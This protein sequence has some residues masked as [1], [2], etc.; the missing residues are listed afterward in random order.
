MT[1]LLS[2]FVALAWGHLWSAD[3]IILARSTKSEALGHEIDYL[4]Y[5]PPS[6]VADGSVR[7]P[8]L[9]LLHGRGDNFRAWTTVKPDVDRLIYEGRVPPFI[10]V[11]PDAPSSRRA[12]YYVDSEFGGE[13]GLPP[14][15][16]VESAFTGDL[17]T[18]IDAEYPTR[19]VRNGRFVAG[20]SMGGYGALRFALAHPE[21]FGAAIV[22][23]PAVYVPLPP[24]DS[25]A[26]EFGAFGRGRERFLDETYVAKNYPAILPHFAVKALP[27]DIFIGVGDDE[28]ANADPLLARHDLDYEAHSLYNRLRRVP[29]IRAELRVIDG[30]HDWRAWRPLF[31]EGLVL[32]LNRLTRPADPR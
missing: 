32:V 30:G 18:H 31:V 21:I 24:P 22:L 9:Y 10:A 7:Y 12:G 25:S 13:P 28:Y 15:E 2:G 23:S 17:V 20:Y 1:S 19:A 11:M 14:G 6:Y 26:R 5:L 27:L 4:L 8:V 3:G 16:T 29:G